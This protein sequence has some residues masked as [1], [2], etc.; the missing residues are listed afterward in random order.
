MR[1][2]VIAP[3]GQTVERPAEPGEALP[4]GRVFRSARPVRPGARLCRVPAGAVD[5]GD[6]SA[7]PALLAALIESAGGL[8]LRAW[9]ADALERAD[10][11]ELAKRAAARGPTESRGARRTAVTIA[12]TAERFAEFQAARSAYGVPVAAI[13]REAV[14]S[15]VCAIHA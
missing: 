5:R 8:S 10:V 12:I 9:L 4:A 2:Y 11:F 14:R 15:A 7:D 6:L 1:R 3:D 13:A